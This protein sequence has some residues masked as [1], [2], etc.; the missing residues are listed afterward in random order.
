MSPKT[1]L[2]SDFFGPGDRWQTVA[3]VDEVGRGC[4][5]GP[6]VTAAV[7]LPETAIAPLQQAGVTDSK[8]LSQR[9]RQQLYPLICE[10]ALATGWGL[11]SVAEIERWNILQATFLAMRRAI[12]KLDRP[13]SRCL[14]DGN[15]QVPQLTYPQT[16]VI[17]G[18]RH[19]I[20]IAAASIL[21]KV[22]RDRL[23]ERLDER[24]PGYALGRHK[25]YGTAQH[26]QAILQLGPTPL[27][28]IRFL[29]SLRQPSQQ[30]DLF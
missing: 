30:I 14:I 25:G 20:T 19:C 24:Y 27:H 12:A 29:R 23:I 7:I 3:G 10:V 13:I 11:A 6:V 1:R 17:Q 16:T 21:A 9:Q 2:D 5:F 18:D 4:L 28:R 8:R 22:W 15:Q 26:R